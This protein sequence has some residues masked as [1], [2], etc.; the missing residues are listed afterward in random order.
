[1]KIIHILAGKAN[2]NSLNGVNKVVHSLAEE[3]IKIGCEV[4]VFGIADNTIERHN[5]NYPLFL[6]TKNSFPF[7]P[8]YTLLRLLRNQDRRTIIHLHSAFISWF[9]FLCIFLRLSRY[10][11]VITPHDAYT[12]NNFKNSLRKILYFYLIESIVLILSQKVHIIGKSE[13]NKRSSIFLKN[14]YILI[15][16]GCTPEENISAEKKRNLI[17]G[18]MGRFKIEHKGLD[19]F[20]QGFSN[21]RK[22]GGNGIVEFVGEGPDCESIKKIVHKSEIQNS[23]NFL[24]VK[25]G[26]E[27]NSFL[28][29]IS[30]FVH[31]S[32]WEGFPTGCLE[33]ASFNIP[34]L[35]SRE[36][37]MGELV[38]KFHAGYVL[39][40][41]TPE[42]IETG[43]F[44]LEKIFFNDSYEA[45]QNC[46]KSMVR[47]ELTWEKINQ[48]I[49][50]TVYT[51]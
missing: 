32:R 44:E 6:I 27:K 47:T 37:N 17:F 50:D 48:K 38:E 36:T 20:L 14:K 16:N 33:A 12:P 35:I 1:M 10:K 15:P 3:Q 42:D 40:D 21:Y 19:L 9:P 13:V 43:L 25:Y 51:N 22:K 23:V 2:P 41:N 34:L 49:V 30:Y 45:M 24:G 28:K 26:D 8:P 11:I 5:H 46:V 39:P 4:K 7:L 29:H 31:T 18:F